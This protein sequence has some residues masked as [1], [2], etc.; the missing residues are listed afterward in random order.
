MASIAS[1]LLH[2]REQ[3]ASAC[4][5]AGRKQE[6][7]QLVAVSKTRTA[8]EIREAFDAGQTVI[9]ESYVQEFLEK[10]D[11]AAL[12]SLPVDWHFIGHL[13]SN[14]IRALIG[15]VSL[16]HSIDKLSTAEELSRRAVL[17]DLTA[18]YLLEVNVSR[19]QSKYGLDPSDFLRAADA[20]FLL[21]NIRLRGLMTIASPEPKQAKKEFRELR[22]RL[23]ELKAIAPDPSLLSELSMG[24]SQD[25]ED[26]ILEGSTII[27]IGTAIFGHR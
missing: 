17:Q 19:E 10:H 3:I 20:F 26:A 6:E 18:D 21:P 9:G 4:N 16:I 14:K 15:K 25:F 12:R 27:R 23:Y 24:M 8:A 11:D 2:V 7:V 13:Q 1:N 22:S 5:K